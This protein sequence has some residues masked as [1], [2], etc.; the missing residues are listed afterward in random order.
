M[1]MAKTSLTFTKQDTGKYLATA[2]VSGN[3][4]IHLKMAQPVDI[5]I[6]QNSDPDDTEPDDTASFPSRTKLDTQVVALLPATVYIES[7]GPVTYGAIIE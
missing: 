2:S 6:K 3:F 4:A 7:S 1:I 5:I